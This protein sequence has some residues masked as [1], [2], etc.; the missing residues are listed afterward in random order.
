[1]DT[2]MRMHPWGS[3]GKTLSFAARSGRGTG[4]GLGI[5]WIFSFAMGLLI[6]DL[7]DDEGLTRSFFRKKTSRK[8][9]DEENEEVE[10]AV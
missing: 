9:K 3:L 7:M 10:E 1:M 8:T 4:R 6:R 5:G 2:N